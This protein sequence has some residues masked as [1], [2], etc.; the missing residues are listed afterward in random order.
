[1]SKWRKRP[2]VVDAFRW[3]G[4][5]DQEEDPEWMVDALR[6]GRARFENSGSEDVRIV[7]RTLEGDMT[8]QPGDYI[9][10]GVKAELY[11]CRADIFEMTYERVEKEVAG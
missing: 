2:V 5:V 8:A 6:E 11:P 7:I 4:D 3:T 9:I 10:R 1:M